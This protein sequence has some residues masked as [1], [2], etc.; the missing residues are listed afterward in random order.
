MA[1]LRQKLITKKG[2]KT[3]LARFKKGVDKLIANV[4]P[5]AQDAQQSEDDTA[6]TDEETA[7]ADED[8]AT[9]DEDPASLDEVPETIRSACAAEVDAGRLPGTPSTVIDFT[10]DEPV[11]LREGAAPSDEALARVRDALPA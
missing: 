6:T 5:E 10:G 11:V 9:T 7:S 2:E 1:F 8:T 4:W 3:F